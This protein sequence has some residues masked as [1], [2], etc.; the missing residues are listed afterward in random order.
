MLFSVVFAV[1]SKELSWCSSV[2]EDCYNAQGS[3]C[4]LKCEAFVENFAK[5]GAAVVL[6]G[7][8]L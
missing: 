1:C 8:V 7:V 6:K 2:R 5:R 4:V 3:S